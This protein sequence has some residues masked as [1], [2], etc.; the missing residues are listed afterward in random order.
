VRADR[1]L[2]FAKAAKQPLDQFIAD[3]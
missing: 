2:K 1:A 3:E